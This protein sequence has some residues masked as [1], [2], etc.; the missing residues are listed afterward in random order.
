MA[1]SVDMISWESWSLE[2]SLHRRA[3]DIRLWYRLSRDKGHVE[4]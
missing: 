4:Y 2:C 1:R 3:K